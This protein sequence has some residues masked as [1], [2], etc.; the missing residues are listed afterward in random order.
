MRFD[1]SDS[2]SDSDSSLDNVPL[3]RK[4]SDSEKH[5]LPT[6]PLSN[7]P[8]I[9]D[10]RLS[11]DRDDPPESDGELDSVNAPADSE[12]AEVTD[13]SDNGLLDDKKDLPNPKKRRWTTF[14]HNG[15]VFPPPYK[16]LPQDVKLYVDG[17]P[18]NLSL[19]AEEMAYIYAKSMH[20]SHAQKPLFIR[21][22]LED[23]GAAVRDCTGVEI[24]SI[25]R[26]DF[27]K[28]LAHIEA[29]RKLQRE[30]PVEEKEKVQQA[31]QEEVEKYGYV[32]IDGVKEPLASGFRIEPPGFYS[33]RGDHPKLGKYKRRLV[34][35]DFTLNLSEGV[36]VP[37]PPPGHKWGEI[38]HNPRAVWTARF[39]DPLT[40]KDKYVL[41]TSGSTTSN[42]SEQKKFDL[43]RMLKRE[44]GYVR[45][46]YMNMLKSTSMV[47]REMG[48]IIYLVDKFAFRIGHDKH[49]DNADT[50]GC[51]TLRCEHVT[52]KPPNRVVFDFLGKDSIRYYN[53]VEVHPQVYTNLRIFKRAPK[54][55]KDTVFMTSGMNMLV[56]M[57][58][59]LPGLTPKVFRTYNAS[60]LMQDLLADV[61]DD[62]TEAEKVERFQD[63]NRKVAILCNHKKE[64]PPSGSL[65][66]VETLQHTLLEKKWDLWYH[67]LELA[68]SFSEQAEALRST[69][70]WIFERDSELTDDVIEEIHTR[71][72]EKKV[73]L[74]YSSSKSAAVAK[75]AEAK[76]MDVEL[77]KKE[78]LDRQLKEAE[79]L[80]EKLANLRM[81]GYHPRKL[82]PAKVNIVLNQIKKAESDIRKTLQAIE[83]KQEYSEVALDTSKT[84]Y[85]D[86]RLVVRYSKRHNIPLEKF[87]NTAQRKK[88]EWAFDSVDEDW[89]F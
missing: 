82:G 14:E 2:G 11:S 78:L 1:S 30:L 80:K 7:A 56:K 22:F 54:Q 41:P 48:T 27:S 88:F 84:N 16:P 81:N 19:I 85:I 35:E 49:E 38:V 73:K 18:L 13:G 42:A 57:N 20:L 8:L 36:K 10:Q 25:E 50:V 21:N 51:T 43:A 26:C 47:E 65:R 12:L 89:I 32:Y 28:I 9:S 77:Y 17:Q 75:R 45:K 31:R 23:F 3:K 55:A 62:L 37:D 40:G 60:S 6:P 34:P 64:T 15:V 83:R 52:L 61:P 59:I 29:Q 4:L 87:L 71:I 5:G 70:P 66:I 53:E 33:G 44:I 58:A 79:T 72:Y 86:P 69:K 63:A 39:F 24:T 76:N 68:N 46:Y 74:A 67:A